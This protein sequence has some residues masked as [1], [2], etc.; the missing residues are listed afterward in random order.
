M[1]TV[2]V[3]DLERELSVPPAVAFALVSEP[4]RMNRWSEARVE[5]VLGGDAGHPGGTGALRRVRPRMMGREVVLE[6][7]IERAEAPGLLVYR[8][9]AGGGVKQHRGTITITPSARGSRVHWRVEATLAALPLEWAARAALRPSL[10]RSLDAM[11]RVATEM[12]DHVEVTLP[13]LRSLDELA[14]SRAL[15]R[16]AEAC[17]ESQ[18]AYADMLLERDDDR[19]WFA[20]VYEHV[21]E[22]QLIACA[23]G[24]FDHPAWVLRLVI[25][26]HG[27]WEENL[28]IRLGERSG[29]VEAHWVKAHRRAETAA[30]DDATVFVRAMRSIHA[31]MRAH[32]EDD[33]PRAIAKVHLSSY[34]GRADLAR[35]RAD[36]LRMGDIF[37]E[38]SAKIREVLPR[39]AWTPRERVLDVLTPD[40]MRGALIEKRYYPIARRRR[41]AFERAVGLVRVLG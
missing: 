17:M 28:A 7:V 12:D 25:A 34:A 14:E 33:L 6:E 29:D 19:G 39:E 18:R 8:V 35:F 15:L 4:D 20:R 30:R 1:G 22:G 10:E 9:L 37:L 11:A 27:L 31:G 16:E 23:A 21:T 24:R 13:P 2:L 32:I 38:A 5:R 41:E 26:F 36:Y 40:A 3:L